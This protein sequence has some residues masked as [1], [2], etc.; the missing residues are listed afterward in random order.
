MIELPPLGALGTS[1]WHVLLDLRKATDGWTLVGG[2]MVLLHGLEHEMAPARISVDIDLIA[3]VRARPR[4][5]PLIVAALAAAGFVIGEPDPDGYAHRYSRERIVVDLLVP[6]HAGPRTDARTNDSTVSTPVSGGTYALQ[7]SA[8][9]EVVVDGRIGLVPLPDL[10]GAILIK[11]RAAVIDRRRGPD[12]H[13]RDLA[14]LCSL[15]AEPLRLRDELGAKNCGRVAGVT[16]LSDPAHEAWLS[17]PG[18][19]GD[20]FA[21]FRLIAGI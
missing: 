14:F 12:R 13:Y 8:D 21:A 19:A 10:A 9:I 6:D 17:L 18:R 11:A 5:M 20:A 15:I 2:Q 1:L 7:R 3:D 16:A 4:R